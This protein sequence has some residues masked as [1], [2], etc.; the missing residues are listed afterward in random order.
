MKSFSASVAAAN[1]RATLERLERE[2]D[3]AKQLERAGALIRSGKFGG[4][5][6]EIYDGGFVRVASS[7]S[8]STP[9]EELR[10]I[11]FTVNV[12]DKSAGGRA[13]A[14]TMTAGL[15][16]MASKEKRTLILTIATDR[17]VH[18]LKTTGGM[19][20]AE[21]KAGQALEAAGQSVIEAR[22]TGAASA[23]VNQ[24]VVVNTASHSGSGPGEKLRQLAE[25]H[26]DGILSDDEFNEAKQ[27]L[28]RDL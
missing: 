9:F 11:K 14:A 24:T 20:R 2:R 7:M 27:R 19:G 4:R 23:T 5:T 18:T 3:Q 22:R 26:R 1:E 10:S 8:A 28:L 13:L 21:D 12:Q 16:L 6:I 17:Q 15:S 25:L